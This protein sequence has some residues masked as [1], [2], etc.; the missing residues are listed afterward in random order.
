LPPKIKRGAMKTT[1]ADNRAGMTVAND[2]DGLVTVTPRTD[3]F[4]AWHDATE[5]FTKGVARPVT[6]ELLDFLQATGHGHL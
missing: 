5:V 3:F 6:V 4:V 1:A 2:P